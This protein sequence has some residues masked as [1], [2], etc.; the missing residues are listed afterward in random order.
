MTFES[1]AVI[2]AN[3]DVAVPWALAAS[4]GFGIVWVVFF[5]EMFW[6]V[7]SQHM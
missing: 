7:K 1:F 3:Y 2:R 5:V 4:F 6:W